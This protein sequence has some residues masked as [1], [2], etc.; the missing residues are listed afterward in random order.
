MPRVLLDGFLDNNIYTI[1]PNLL[2]YMHEWALAESVIT[3]ARN[4]AEKEHFTEIKEINIQLGELQQIEQDIF[5]YALDELMDAEHKLFDGTKIN[6]EIEK[7]TLQCNNCGHTWN[8][9]D[10]KTEL[11]DNESEAIHFL[12]E[13]AFVHMKCLKC[14]SPDFKIV[15]GRGVTIKSIKGSKQE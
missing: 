11:S 10:V 7:S 8:F 4:T 14:G 15:S 3:T 5:K 1:V 2:F 6:I 12:P 13:V 9:S